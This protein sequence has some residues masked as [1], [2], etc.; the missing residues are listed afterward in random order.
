M[1]CF[2]CSSSSVVEKDAID[3][4][5]DQL[6]SLQSLFPDTAYPSIINRNGALV[7]TSLN[8]EKLG[9]DLTAIISA[10]QSAAKHFSVIL[11]M[12][13]CPHL[14]IEGDSQIFTLFS[15]HG[16]YILVFFNNKLGADGA[17]LE[18]FSTRPELKRIIVEMNKVLMNA[19][20]EAPPNAK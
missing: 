13:G 17:E 1:S 14:K 8:E 19:L 2:L 12:T 4:L 11:G 5:K 3:E 7:A 6:N 18:D 16:D 15:L 10:I 20:D 9:I